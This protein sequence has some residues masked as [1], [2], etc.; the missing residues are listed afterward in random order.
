VSGSKPRG[1][2]PKAPLRILLSEGASTSAREAITALGLEGHHI[3]IAD[4]SRHC[5]GRFSR[6]VRRFHRC[7]PLGSDPEGYRDFIVEITA[8]GRFDVLVPIHEQG[9]LISTIA[10]RLQSSVSIALPAFASYERAVSRI[11][12]GQLLAELDLPHPRTAIVETRRDLANLREFPI[13][14]KAEIGTASRAVWIVGSTA[15]LSRAVEEIDGANAFGRGVVVQ[16]FVDGWVEHAQ[17]VFCRGRLVAMHGFRQLLR[18]AGGGDALKESIFRPAVREHLAQI[19]AALAWH[20]ALS[21][22][23]MC[24]QANDIPLYIDCN[25]RLV[26]PMS[27]LLAG[28]DL[29]D[30]LLRVSLG[31]DVP[32]QPPSR[33]GVRS[34]L[35][36]QILLGMASRGAGRR[37]LLREGWRAA[38]AQGRYSGSREELTPAS[39]DWPSTIPLLATAAALTA[40]PALADRLAAGGWGSHLLTPGAIRR[41]R[42]WARRQEDRGT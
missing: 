28:I 9:Y 25:P 15:G 7:P 6:F 21:L 37:E 34:H 11:G 30:V 29:M 14:L 42:S 17:A 24:R 20:G 36:I 41:I 3:E 5:L 40:S 10:E 18:G 22:D 12:F 38:L 35:T 33:A 32:E 4:P 13:V 23:Y 26:E 2:G 39:L 16:D 1:E 19:G 27:G 8:D 31:E